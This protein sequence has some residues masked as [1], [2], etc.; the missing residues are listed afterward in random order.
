MLHLS[1][2][3]FPSSKTSFRSAF[4]AHRYIQQNNMGGH[5]EGNTNCVFVLIVLNVTVVNAY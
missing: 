3:K 5:P 4:A 2:S 1:L